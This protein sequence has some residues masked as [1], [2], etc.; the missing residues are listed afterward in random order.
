M[1]DRYSRRNFLKLGAAL[2]AGGASVAIDAD[3][4]SAMGTGGRDTGVV[5]SVKSYCPFCQVRC[6]YSAQVRGGKVESLVGES[7]NPWTGGAM[8]PKGMSLVDLVG[9]PHR[10]TEPILKQPDG[11]WKRI[12]YA[13]AIDL[14]VAK[15]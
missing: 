10:I 4:A 2:A 5:T 11:G 13:E 8:C 14:V 6:T 15:V 12:S 7:G 3:A 9:S 1:P